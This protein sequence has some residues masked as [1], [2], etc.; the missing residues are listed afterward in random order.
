MNSFGKPILR[1][2]FVV[3]S[4]LMRLERTLDDMFAKAV[5]QPNTVQADPSPEVLAR[6]ELDLIWIRRKEFRKLD[7]PEALRDEAA[8]AQEGL[9][10][11]VDRVGQLLAAPQ[12]AQVLLPLIHADAEMV[13]KALLIMVEE[14]RTKAVLATK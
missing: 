1:D 11:Y 12:K 5:L 4:D 7:F 10:R 13:R 6:L 2:A 3:T 14:R 8:R 9:E